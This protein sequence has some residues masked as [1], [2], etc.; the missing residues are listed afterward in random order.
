MVNL[1]FA[2]DAQLT[3]PDRM[4]LDALQKDYELFQGKEKRNPGAIDAEDSDDSGAK[5]PRYDSVSP[6]GR[7]L[8]LSTH[9]SIRQMQIFF[10]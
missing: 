9:K 8:D 10:L 1:Y 3:V 6:E 2:P 4:V 7:L 5:H